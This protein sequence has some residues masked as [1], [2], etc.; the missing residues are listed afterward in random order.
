MRNRHWRRVSP[1]GLFSVRLAGENA[2]VTYVH[3]TIGYIAPDAAGARLCTSFG[4]YTSQAQVWRRARRRGLL[5]GLTLRLIRLRTSAGRRAGEEMPNN[6]VDANSP[7]DNKAAT[8]ARCLNPRPLGT[9][10]AGRIERHLSS[11][12]KPRSS[13]KPL[14]GEAEVVHWGHQWPDRTSA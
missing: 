7:A 5:R 12:R 6:P 14:A 9:T 2:S 8:R 4:L 1:S 3:E 10:R 13:I 11:E